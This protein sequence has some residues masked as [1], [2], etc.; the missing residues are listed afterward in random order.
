MHILNVQI[1]KLSVLKASTSSRGSE[2]CNT[3]IAVRIK[4]TVFDSDMVRIVIVVADK[5]LALDNIGRLGT[6]DKSVCIPQRGG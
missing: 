6:N 2:C 3:H 5:G 4:I 1:D